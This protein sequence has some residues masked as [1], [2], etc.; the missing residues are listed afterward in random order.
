[1]RTIMTNSIY[2]D[3]DH[4]RALAQAARNKAEQMTHRDAKR[5]LISI[6]EDYEHL[7]E[8]AEQKAKKKAHNSGS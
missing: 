1:L 7:A 6:A 5:T 4:W 3:P 2:D 8:R